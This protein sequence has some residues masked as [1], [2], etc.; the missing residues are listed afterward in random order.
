[1]GN[2]WEAHCQSHLTCLTTRRCGTVNY[3]HTLVQPGYCPFCLGDTALSAS[4][5]LESWTRDFK[6]WGYVNEH[7]DQC[8]WPR[9]CPRPLCD[10]WIE[11][12]VTLQFHLVDEHDF[13][14]TRPG[15]AAKLSVLQDERRH[16]D[17]QMRH[18]SRKRKFSS[19][20]TELEWMPPHHINDMPLSE[21]EP[22]NGQYPKRPKQ[23][24]L[25]ICPTALNL[26]LLTT[27]PLSMLR[28]RSCCLLHAH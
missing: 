24:L 21:R 4:Q 14:R 8:R 15:T 7:L 27:N 17:I 25:T 6:L 26:D 12:A 1:M 19:G 23:T 9:S 13:S 28:I 10:T 18:S 20:P 2:G 11:D 22:F 5:R 16:S 3:C